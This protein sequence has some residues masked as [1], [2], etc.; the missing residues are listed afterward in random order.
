MQLNEDNS[1][2]LRHKFPGRRLDQQAFEAP[3]GDP[4]GQPTRLALILSQALECL[5]RASKRRIEDPA[6][7]RRLLDD[8]WWRLARLTTLV[9]PISWHLLVFFDQS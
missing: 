5:L 4:F 8:I 1:S 7:R 6:D 9:G 2:Q 3:P